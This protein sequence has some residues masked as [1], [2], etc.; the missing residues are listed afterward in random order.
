[1]PTRDNALNTW[2]P[3]KQQTY[4]QRHPEQAL[5][6]TALLD[7]SPSMYGERAKALRVSFNMYLAW[8]QK[9]ADPMSL[10]HVRVF[11]TKLAEGRATPL[12]QTPPLSEVTYDP[13][14]GDGTA[15]YHAVG[16]TCTQHETAGQHFLIVFTDGLDNRSKALGWSAQ[17]VCTLVTTLE[18]EQG[19][20]GVFL[21]A[22]AE[23]LAV[24]KAMGFSAGNCLE[25]SSDR[26]PEAF[27]R[28][29]QATQRYLAASVP[30]RKLLVQGGLF[31]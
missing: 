14:G 20:A 3:D 26:I 17:Q 23:A 31:V 4:R 5:T 29:R 1:M 25:F 2:T 13:L 19:W 15:L 28:L 30:A 12:C 16:V 27:Q 8:L 6:F 18:Q 7:A 11:S 22:F 9:H 10:V 21:G 24:G